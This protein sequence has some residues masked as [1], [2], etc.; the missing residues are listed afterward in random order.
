[1]SKPFQMTH[2]DFGGLFLVESASLRKA[3]IIESYPTIVV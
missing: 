2:T 3:P 1:M